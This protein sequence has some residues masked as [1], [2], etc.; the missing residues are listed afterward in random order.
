ML[1]VFIVGDL[2]GHSDGDG[3]AQRVAVDDYLGKQRLFRLPRSNA[4][5]QT[6]LDAGMH[7]VG[8]EGEDCLGVVLHGDLVGE[9]GAAVAVTAVVE[10]KNVVAHVLV[11][12]QEH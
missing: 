3:R 8:Y 2:S 6:N 10:R 11:Q 5:F 9:G 12:L 7:V 4:L 1:T